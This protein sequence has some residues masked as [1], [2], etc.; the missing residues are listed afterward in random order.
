MTIGITKSL[1]LHFKR[2]L[3]R[4]PF[5]LLTKLVMLFIVTGALNNTA[6]AQSFVITTSSGISFNPSLAA[7][8]E[9]TTTHSLA[10]QLS[11]NSK[12]KTYSLYASI[13]STN[14]SPSTTS[15]SS[16]P[17]QMKFNQTTGS[18]A[19]YATSSNLTLQP[20]PTYTTLASNAT[21]TGTKTN[22]TVDYDLILSSIGYTIPPGTYIYNLTFRYID[23]SNNTIDQTFNITITVPTVMTLT[24][25]QNNAST[26]PFTTAA[27]LTNG[28]TLSNV[29]TLR[30]KSNVPWRC[31]IKTFL[32]TLTNSGTYSTS[33]VPT[34]K[35]QAIVSPSPAITLADDPSGGPGQLFRAGSAGNS[36]VS[37]NTFS[38]SLYALPG[39]LMGPGNYTTT[40]VYTIM[41]A[42]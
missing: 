35:I 23:A 17:I 8:I 16:P 21:A 39:F 28:L 41:A 2:I 11:I 7:D 19:G 31:Y 20:Y 29:N 25:Q 9:G 32:A 4:L 30:I 24:I 40:L 18:T 15:F 10:F 26:F 34:S 37:G 27:Q 6:T 38:M 36:G 12:S 33:S 1:F 5:R 3:S 22:V 42:P 13:S 14:F